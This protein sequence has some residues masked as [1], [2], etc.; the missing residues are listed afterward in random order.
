MQLQ[1]WLRLTRACLSDLHMCWCLL[2][3]G[4]C[5]Y[6][7][8]QQMNAQHVHPVVSQIVQTAFFRYFKVGSCSAQHI[9]VEGVPPYGLQAGTLCPAPCATSRAAAAEAAVLQHSQL[10]TQSAAVAS[11]WCWPV[12]EHHAA[13]TASSAAPMTCHASYAGPAL[14]LVAPPSLVPPP[15]PP[16]C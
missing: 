4:N 5:T 8:V 3:A 13:Q 16:P 1:H 11:S 10:Q 2:L 15:T 12:R 14:Q 9:G 6:S 7:A